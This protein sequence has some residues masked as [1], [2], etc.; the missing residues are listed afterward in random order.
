MR[1]TIQKIRLKRVKTQA[2]SE[3][4]D[5]KTHPGKKTIPPRKGKAKDTEDEGARGEKKGDEADV[6]EGAAK[7]ELREA[8]KTLLGK[9]I[10]G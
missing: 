8:I 3:D 1:K 9:Y 7:D 2:P 6:N 5:S 4:D 10:K